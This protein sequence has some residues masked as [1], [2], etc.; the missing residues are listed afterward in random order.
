LLSL[1][2]AN[3]MDDP[4]LMQTLRAHQ[5]RALAENFPGGANGKKD[6]KMPKKTENNAIKPLS[7]I[8]VPC[9]K[10]QGGTAP[11][12]PVADAHNTNILSSI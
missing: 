12:P 5:P 6:R 11:L 4:W 10:I 8:F 1:E 2:E 3:G 7:T 9:I